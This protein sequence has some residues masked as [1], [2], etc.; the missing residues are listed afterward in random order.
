VVV[1]PP[2]TVQLDGETLGLR[3]EVR[4]RVLPGAVRVIVPA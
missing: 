4:A 2:Q 1:D 3:A